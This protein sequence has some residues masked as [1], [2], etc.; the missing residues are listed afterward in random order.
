MF[1]KLA[2]LKFGFGHHSLL[3]HLIPL[4]LHRAPKLAVLIFDKYWEVQNLCRSTKP[5]WLARLNQPQNARNYLSQKKLRWSTGSAIYQCLS[6][7]IS[8]RFSQPKKL[9]SEAS[10]RAGGRLSGLVP[11]LDL[12]EYEFEKMSSWSSD[13]GEQI[14]NQ[15]HRQHEDQWNGYHF[16]FAHIV[17]LVWALRNANPLKHFRLHWQRSNCDP[18]HVDT[19]VRAAI[20]RGL[21]VL[22]FKLSYL[23]QGYFNLPFTLFHYCKTLVVLKL[24]GRIVLD[25]PSSSLGFP[26]LKVL[27]LQSVNAFAM[28]L[29]FPCFIIWFTCNMGLKNTLVGHVRPL[30]L[31]RAP[32]LAE[33]VF[34]KASAT[35]CFEA[36]SGQRVNLV[37]DVEELALITLPSNE[38]IGAAFR[39]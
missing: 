2:Y 25:P 13:S 30:L 6:S 8:F 26:S 11:K 9:L 4:L 19:W 10:C 24:G 12:D 1:H 34:Y 39:S 21:E 5:G 36:V 22:D 33:L 31:Q 14:P 23:P 38:T 3:E 27:H 16:T 7:A 18:I 29:I 17:S 20:S 35:S 32:K 28:R 37:L 15:N